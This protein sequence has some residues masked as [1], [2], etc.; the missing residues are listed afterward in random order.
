MNTKEYVTKYK[1]NVQD[2]K[3]NHTDFVSD[4][5]ND[6]IT[7]LE[8]G[9]STKNFKGYENAVRA[10]RMKWDAIN[11]KTVGCLPDKLWNF[12]YATV[13]AKTKEELFPEE[14]AKQKEFNEQKR[15]EWEERKRWREREDSFF[16]S[17]LFLGAMTKKPVPTES[18]SVLE[19]Q[20]D[21]TEEQVIK[22]YR[23]LSIKHH[24]DKGGNKEKFIEIT[25]AKNKILSYLQ[26]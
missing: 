23:E 17:F 18:Y 10:I 22:K 24:P 25:E 2:N 15:K 4:L 14:I 16:W 12:F 6:F 21:A 5:T 1:L 20:T 11:N 3:F 19:L 7:L 9:N 8:V 26:K 13:I